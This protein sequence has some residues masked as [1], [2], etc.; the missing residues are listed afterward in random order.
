VILYHLGIPCQ[1]KFWFHFGNFGRMKKEKEKRDRIPERGWFFRCRGG[2][3]R[4]DGPSIE[5]HGRGPSQILTE[6]QGTS[7]KT[8]SYHRD[9]AEQH[10]PRR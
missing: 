3:R 10:G 1:E 7:E 8:S 6:Q 5:P 4:G 9:P 2:R